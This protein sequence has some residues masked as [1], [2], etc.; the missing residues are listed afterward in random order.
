MKKI[1]T[2]NP[3]S[4]ILMLV[5]VLLGT[6]VAGVSASSSLRSGAGSA[7]PAAKTS[8]GSEA[9]VQIDNFA[10][11]PGAIVVKA[12]TQVTWINHD[13]IPHTVDSTD[14]KFKSGALD[15][16]DKFEFRFLE[17]GEYPFYCRI[18]PRMTGKI[19]VQP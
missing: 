14:G 6:T 15:T 19:V 13:D 12:G 2:T 4:S 10:F 9:E 18:H 5:T 8:K 17:P 7:V 1:R 3:K 16:D 11:T